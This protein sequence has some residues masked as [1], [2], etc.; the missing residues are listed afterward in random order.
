MAD[1]DIAR[2][3][4]GDHH[5]DHIGRCAAGSPIGDRVDVVDKCLHAA[6]ARTH[7]D[8]QALAIDGALD[9]KARIVHGLVRRCQ[10]KLN[11]GVQ[12]LGITLA[13]VLVAVKTLDLGR[14]LNG[15]RIGIEVR[16]RADAA[17]AGAHGR[18]G[19]KRGIAEW[20]YGTD[21]GDCNSLFH[22]GLLI[23]AVVR[24]WFLHRH[25][26]VDAH[27]LARN[28]GSRITRQKAHHAG[29]FLGARHAF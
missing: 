25:S 29:H 15:K 10:G 19:G 9:I 22:L 18:P 28:V 21:T 7:V 6:H 8:A 3:H 12:V 5:R 26:A 2:S 14:H 20:R 23:Q 24:P 16:D 27:D 13:K 17:R 1:C 11:A 4:I